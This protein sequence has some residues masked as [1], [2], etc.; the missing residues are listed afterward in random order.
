MRLFR[1]WRDAEVL[2]ELWR[3]Q[4]PGQTAL[5]LAVDAPSGSVFVSDGWG[6]TY[7][8]L[9][10]HRLDLRTG[11]RLASA[12]TAQRAVGALRVAHGALWV[13]TDRRLVRLTLAGLE[14]T[15]RWDGLVGHPQQL[16]VH[17]AQAVL[18]GGLAPTIS[19][20]DTATGSV[21]RRR[22]GAQPV[23]G[24]APDG[25]RVVSAVH[26]SRWRVDAVEGRLVT[27]PG[28]PPLTA[29]CS[30]DALAGSVH[31]PAGSAHASPGPTSTAA[32][33]T[34]AV[35]W[36]VAAGRERTDRQGGEPL[37]RRDPGR[38][39]VAWHDERHRIALGAAG[40]ALFAGTAGGLWVLTGVDG[41]TLQHVDTSAG[42]VG[43]RYRAPGDAALRHVDATA[44]V[45]LAVGP[46]PAGTSDAWLHALR[47]PDPASSP[48]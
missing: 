48:G 24:G 41:Q 36:G 4:V 29:L 44:G 1:T 46:G 6:V 13:A 30:A 12:R 21:R 7:A 27:E 16:V 37:V 17:G 10:V 15:A 40:A 47:L 22:A 34:G 32:G 26:G 8:S 19:V 28:G 38:E 35:L 42:S 23:L 20:L 11:A 9:G 45:A 25:V 43:A 31:V 3:A 2:S 5:T 14:E 39:L 18:A 33:A